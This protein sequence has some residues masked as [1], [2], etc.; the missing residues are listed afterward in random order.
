MV[1]KVIGL[2]Q[3]RQRVGTLRD[4]FLR[5]IA[6][7]AGVQNRLHDARPVEFLCL[8]NL[9][10]ARHAAGVVVV[11]VWV[12]L[13]DRVADIAIHDLH[14]I[15]V[16]EQLE[17]LGADALHQ[18]RAPRDMIALV[19]LVVALAVQQFHAQRH[20]QFFRQRQKPFQAKGA[21]LQALRIVEA[22]AVARETNQTLEARVRR[23]LQA[24]FV[25]RH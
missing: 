15:N 23:F 10:A 8:V 2:P 11:E 22:G 5:D 9:R 19:I 1:Y 12:V 18:L 17:P 13:L 21:I 20:L 4:K 7:E 24:L 6:F 14:V 16:V 25:G 3:R